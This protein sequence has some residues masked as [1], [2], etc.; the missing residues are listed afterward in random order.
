MHSNATRVGAILVALQIALT[1]AVIA[2]GMSII[3]GHLAAMRTVTGMDEANIFTFQNRWVGDP[4]NLRASIDADMA[5]LRGIPGWWMLRLL[6][7]SHCLAA[8]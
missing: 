4:Q 8:D 2:N 6:T 1:L 5:A 7:P 3:Q